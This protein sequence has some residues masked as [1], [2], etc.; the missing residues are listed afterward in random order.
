MKKFVAALAVVLTLSAC[1]PVEA[2]APAFPKENYS[3]KVQKRIDTLAEKK[4]CKSLQ[5]EFDV[6]DGNKNDGKA[7][8]L[9]YIDHA[10]TEAGCY[11]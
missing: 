9:A 10:M 3:K 7:D 8:L 5:D 11:G 2:E 1:G 6:A 4:Q